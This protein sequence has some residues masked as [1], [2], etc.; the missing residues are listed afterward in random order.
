MWK[1]NFFRDHFGLDKKNMG[2]EFR[3]ERG[4]KY[5]IPISII[6]G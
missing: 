2:M 5:V 4:N 3:D 1:T 6:I